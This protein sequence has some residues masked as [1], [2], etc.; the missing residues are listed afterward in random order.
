[1]EYFP[2]AENYWSSS[3]KSGTAGNF[4]GKRVDKRPRMSYNTGAVSDYADVAHLVE[5][6]LAKVEVASSSLVIR[7]KTGIPSQGGGILFAYAVCPPHSS[8]DNP[9]RFP[10]PFVLPVPLPNIS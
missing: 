4:S 6:N 8:E 5:R 3:Q 10:S 1:M 2:I 9:K 7:S